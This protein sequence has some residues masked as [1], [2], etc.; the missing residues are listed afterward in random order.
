MSLPTP[1]P[2]H[3]RV[4]RPEPSSTQRRECSPGP[5]PKP[6]APARFSFDVEVTDDGTPN[7]SDSET[8]TVTVDETNQPPVLAG[9]GDHTTDEQVEFTFTATATDSDVPANTLT[10]TLSGEP[11][12][13]VIDPASGVFTW[14]P[15]ETQ[16]PGSYGFDVEVTDDGSPNLSDSETITVTVDEVNLAPTVTDPG[17]QT[18]PEGTVISLPITASDS[19]VP[20]NTLSYA[21]S[22]LPAG[23][24]IDP[25]SGEISGTLSF[26]CAATSPHTVTVTVTDNGTPV[27]AGQTVFDWTCTPVNQP[28][29]L[30]PVGDHTTD[31]Q[32]ELTFTASASDPDIPANTLT[33]S[34]SGEPAGAVIDPASG[35]FTW[36]PSEAQGP[37]SFTFDIEVTDDGVP[38]LSDSETITVTVDETNTAP[39]LG[40]IG[41]H[42]TNEQ[43]LLTFTAS[44]TDTD[45]PANTLSFT[46]SGEPA[47]AVIDPASGVFTWTPSEAQGPGSF[48]FDVEVTDDGVP[49]LSDSETITVTVDE[50]NTAPVLGA[51]GDH[52]TD[53]QVL[54]TFT[55]SATDPDV[56]ANTLSFTLS[57]EPAGAVID[58]AS[59]VFTWTPTEAQGPGS[60]T[61]DVEVTDDGVPNLSDTETI[62]V[63]VDET[64]TAPVLG[65]IGDH[66]TDEQVLLTFTASATDPDV[67]A[68][69]LSFTLSGEPAGAVID[70]ASGVF[71]W[72]PTE[73]QGP[74]SFT[75]DV[76]VTDDGVPN[77]SDT[78]TITVTVNEVNTPP[79]LAGIG[80]QPGTEGS[81]ISFTATATDSDIPANTLTFSLEDGTDPVPAGASIDPVSGAFTWTPTETQGPGSYT[82]NIRV[83]DNTALFDQQAVTFTI[84]E[85]NQPPV[86]GAIGD[87]TIDEQVLLTFTASA[88]DTDIP[89]NT[90]SFTLSGEPTGAVIDPLTGVFTWTPTE[91]QGPGSFTFD[92]EVTDDGVPNLSDSET[93]TVTVDEVD[94]AP[95]LASIGN[96]TTDEQTLLTFTASAS[97]PDI[98]ANTLT[99]SLSG[100]PAGAVIDPV[101]GVFTWTPSEAQGPG[102]YGFD[103][104]VTDDGV[105][106]L[107]DTETITVTVNEV[108]VAPTVTN[109]GDQT[110]PEGTV[111]SLFIAATDSDIPANTLSYAASGLP[112]G[113]GIDPVTGEIRGTLSFGCAATSPHTVT[114]TVTDNGT[115]VL[116]GQTVFDWTCTPVNQPPMLDPVGDHTIDEQVLLT[117]TATASDPDVRR[118]PH[119]HTVG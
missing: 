5:P 1:S 108:N 2:T 41:D 44:A 101:T 9:I 57:G 68:N 118:H 46:L 75:F 17:D 81:P 13:A 49:N 53:E 21:A 103:V 12:G 28:P 119:L 113:L 6:K 110:D 58:P 4:N 112:A 52:T 67:P 33:Y 16:G 116:A 83:T 60:F 34:L 88:T 91:A 95:V 22:G 15:T 23:L 107:S 14:T 64:N 71:T 69:T 50:T 98:P 117:F 104:I 61:F 109:P 45:V 114:V 80:N 85:A 55:A 3:C 93:I 51:I 70:P 10:Y 38:N 76:E 35:V 65:A 102:S 105:P 31:E 26:G 94:T 89:A 36:T 11:A 82:F 47:G 7:L 37:G 99:Y 66:T 30:D 77:L 42:T 90:L 115:P 24:G 79:V 106:N 111:I 19:D 59:G 74:G 56:P 25:V 48:T 27:L 39:V 40:A 29:V 92:I 97:D 86:L 78:E 43:V 73:V 84:N 62:T 100:E 87:H 8:I 20:V 54:L 32:V 18:D 63:T 72:T 96:H